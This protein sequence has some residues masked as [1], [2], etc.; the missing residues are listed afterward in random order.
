MSKTLLKLI[1]DILDF[2]KI[3]AGKLDILP[4]NYNIRALLDTVSSMLRFIAEKK[5]LAFNMRISDDIPEVLY[6]DEIRVRQI[7]TNI[8]SNS[9]KYTREGTIDIDVTKTIT[10]GKTYFQIRIKDTGI[11][12][13]KEDI[14]KLFSAFQ[15]LDAHENRGIVGTGLGLAICKRLTDMMDGSIGAESEYGKGSVFTVRLPL[16]EGAAAS[17]QSDKLCHVQKNCDFVTA[18]KDAGLRA[19]VVDDMPENL[20]VASGFLALHDIA[21]DT[22]LSGMEALEKVKKIKYDIVFMDQMMPEMDGLDAARYIRCLEEKTGDH[23][24][25]KVP[26]IALSANAVMGAVEKFIAAGMNDS[27]SKPIESETLNSKLALWLP[28]EKIEYAAAKKPGDGD[29]DEAYSVFEQLRRV[30]HIDLEDGLIHTGGAPAYI[31]VIKQY[32]SGFAASTL[33]LQEILE[34]KDIDAY[35]I[36]VHALKGI[37][38]TLGVR[39][40]SEWA[41]KLELASADAKAANSGFPEICVNETKPFVKECRRFFDM[42]PAAVKPDNAAPEKDF[43]KDAGNKD[44][45]LTKL[46]KLKTDMETGHANS[47]NEICAELSKLSFDEKTDSFIGELSRLAADFDYYIAKQRIEEFLDAGENENFK[48]YN[49]CC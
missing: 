37:F 12:I 46:E 6:G 30:K 1:N 25:G 2:S 9:I 5:G 20:T 45:L 10:D 24:F 31:K 36:K 14:S 26:I 23:W 4:M 16:V 35:H 49:S 3:E 33:A 27:I 40:L 34:K 29:K 7:F 38:A 43:R 18:K 22:A 42:L 13:K 39:R 17:L 15:Q 28:P 19:L 44:F 8:I 11:G 41:R 48:A 32:C 21:A 47:I